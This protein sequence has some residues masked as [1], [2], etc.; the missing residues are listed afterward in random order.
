LRVYRWTCLSR[1]PTRYVIGE[2]LLLN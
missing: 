1:L 2:I